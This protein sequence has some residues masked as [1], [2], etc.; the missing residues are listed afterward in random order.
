MHITYVYIYIACMSYNFS[1]FAFA[2]LF[3]SKAAKKHGVF[4]GMRA[5]YGQLSYLTA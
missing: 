1:K 5:I 2:T 3:G 4:R